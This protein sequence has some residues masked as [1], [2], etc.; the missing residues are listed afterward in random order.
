[1]KIFRTKSI[2]QSIRDTE[3][4]EHQLRKALGPLDLI[5]FGVGVTIGTGIFVTTGKAAADYAGPAIVIS[6]LLAGLA[7]GLAALCY[8]EFA[9]SVPVSGSAYTFSYAT[10]GEFIA[11]VIGWDLILEFM[12]GASVV[13][14]G[15]SSYF[16]ELLKGLGI[17][18]PA[19][20]AGGPGAVMN[21]PAALIALLLTAV[22]TVGIRTSSIVNLVITCIKVV[23]VLFFIGL[24]IFFVKPANWVPFIPPAIPAAITKPFWD[25]TVLQ[26]L[27]SRPMEYGWPG[28]VSGASLVFFAYIGFD[29][30]A[31]TAEETRNPQKNMPIGI[32]GSLALCTVLY[33]AVSLVMTGIVP[34]T[35]LATSENTAAMA[36]AFSA[37]GQSWAAVL[38]SIGAI[39]GMT[40]VIMIL[41]LGQ[42]RV[43]F[44]MSRDN[45]LPR[46][47]SQVHPRFKTPYRINIIVGIVVAF[48]AAF[49]PVSALEEMTNIGTLTAFILVSIGVIVLRRTRP[50]LRRA[51]RT[52]LVP[53]IPILAVLICFYLM[54]GLPLLTWVRFLVWLAIGVVLYFVY[55]QQHSRL[56]KEGSEEGGL[57]HVAVSEK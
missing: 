32:F 48:T 35:Q 42:S 8:A 45:L 47:F 21:L 38:V 37:I 10:L 49:T 20:I 51:F 27:G 4:P 33:I 53:W 22:V 3:E 19:V 24:G 11:W 2:E 54:L 7:C 28:V 41:M 17:H 43:F 6:F 56:A 13:S 16:G 36:L 1:M 31:T 34:Y 15:W 57:K 55:G 23:V 39:C 30:V 14:V 40:A 18:L 9:S 44:A 46:W 5:V 52:P 25:T 29:I 50:N 12:V 26:M